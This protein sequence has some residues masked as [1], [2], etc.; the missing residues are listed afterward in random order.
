MGKQ[1]GVK[2][3]RGYIKHDECR[4]CARDPL[5]PCMLTP[6]LLESL[7]E[8]N[9]ELSDDAFTPTRLI[10]CPRKAQL[11]QRE[12]WYIDVDHA[13]SAMRGTML[14]ARLELLPRAPGPVSEIRE[15]RLETTVQTKYG[16][17][18]VKGKSDLIVVNSVEE[19]RNSKTSDEPESEV[20]I[21]VLADDGETMHIKVVDYK[22]KAEIGHDLV[23][24]E[25]RHQMQVNI[26]GWLA[27]KAL[28][29]ALAR[30]GLKVVVDELEIFYA[31]TNKPRRFTSAGP[32]M[33]KGKRVSVR[34]LVYEDLELEPIH[35]LR[36]GD[37][38]RWVIKHVEQVIEAREYLPP[39]LEGEAAV[40]CQWCPVRQQ[41]EEL[42]REGI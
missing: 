22:S 19:T 11:K 28:P 41:C 27:T 33:T 4:R 14:H 10:D 5:H 40:I 25:R 16:P 20:L 12:D 35:M 1:V 15:I 18:V 34:P 31:G 39:P 6:Q 26:Y 38:E 37:A 32:L 42:A 8:E 21:G 29:E 24:A 9:Q 13:W 36:A 30:P 7:R 23:R 3:V 17:Q 2:C